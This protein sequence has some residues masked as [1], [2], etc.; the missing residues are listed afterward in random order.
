MNINK[1]HFVIENHFGQNSIV[2]EHTYT[3]KIMKLKVSYFVDTCS[4]M[5]DMKDLPSINR[6]N[7]QFEASVLI[8]IAAISCVLQLNN[9]NEA[10]GIWWISV[11]NIEL[12][13]MVANQPG[14]SVRVTLIN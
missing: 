11:G 10:S 13:P 12:Q 8:W 4:C 5:G 2:N 7:K 3:V 6:L 14:S 9:Q 1:N